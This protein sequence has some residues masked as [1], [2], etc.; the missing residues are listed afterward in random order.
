M[1]PIAESGKAS[2]WHVFFLLGDSI[3][4]GGVS[5]AYEDGTECSETSVRKI[6]MLGYN[7]KERIQIQNTAKFVNQEFVCHIS[8]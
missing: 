3:F 2:I 8:C 1:K 6:Q 7:S 4:I 5:T